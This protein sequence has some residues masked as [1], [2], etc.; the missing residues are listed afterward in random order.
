MVLLSVMMVALCLLQYTRAKAS[1]QRIFEVLDTTSYIRAGNLPA[2]PERTGAV[3]FRDVSFKYNRDGSGD[4]VLSHISF[5]AKPGQV[6]AVI[7]G[8]GEGKST[9][10]NLIP[11]FYDVTAG[12]VL[13]DGTDVRDFPMEELRRRVGQGGN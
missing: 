5:A 11:R 1:A 7:G 6:V 3:E 12:A 13:V 8:T 4:D 2:L 10:I 9:L